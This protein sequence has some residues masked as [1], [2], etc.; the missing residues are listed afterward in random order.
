[1][2]MYVAD[3]PVTLQLGYGHG[4]YCESVPLRKDRHQAKFERSRSQS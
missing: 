3:A 2:Q 4:N 1:M